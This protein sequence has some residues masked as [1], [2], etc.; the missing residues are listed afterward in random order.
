MAKTFFKGCVLSLMVLGLTTSA[1]AADV[2]EL[3]RRIN[4]LSEELDQVKRSGGAGSHDRVS[5]HGYGEMHINGEG[6]AKT[7][8]DNHR[9][10]IGV[11]AELADWIHLNAEIDFE[12]AAQEL[13]FEFGY[14]DFLLSKNLNA[15]AGVVLMPIGYLNENHEPPL[16][17]T[18]ER[19]EFHQKIIPTT[20]NASGAG[21]F[22]TAMDGVNYRLYVTNSLQSIRPDST[23]DVGS[24][25][26]NG[27][28]NGRFRASDGI[29]GGRLQPNN[30][31]MDDIAVSGRLEFTKLY[32]G[33]NVGVS[34]Y[35]GD[36]THGFI[37][38]GGNTTIL[39]ADV[40]YRKQWFEMNSSIANI[41]IDDAAALNTFCGAHSG[42]TTDIAE[43]IFG[44]NIQA[45][46]HLFQL[47][48]KNTTQDLVPFVLYESIRPQDEMPAGA[49]ATS[50]TSNFNVVTVG[51]SY[52]PVPSVALKMDYSHLDFDRTNATTDKFN[53][54]VAYMY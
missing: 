24:G 25:N 4:S 20:W 16:F 19:P 52:M 51:M 49:T 13:E 28:A 31:V 42:C 17:W 22:G 9:F 23:S 27:G 30:R 26:G 37:D 29:R 48:G 50:P 12:H 44:W 2:F 38:E 11:H 41:D 15:R 45:G 46:V 3:E 5:V 18:V 43:N 1:W 33:L 34:F 7:R 39:E 54:G 6:G 32:E 35:N 10:V 8:A 36:T 21:I 14:L 47:L 53:L 40:R